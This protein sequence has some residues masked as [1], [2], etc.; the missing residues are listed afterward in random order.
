MYF[1]TLDF[2]KPSIMVETLLQRSSAF[3][4]AAVLL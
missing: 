4:M 1:K 2:G 3:T